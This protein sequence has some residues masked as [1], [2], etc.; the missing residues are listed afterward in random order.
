VS[1]GE[2]MFQ[3]RWLAREVMRPVDCV[4]REGD[5]AWSAAGRLFQS[6]RSGAPVLDSEGRLVGV[7]SQSDLAAH[8]RENSRAA[9]DFYEEPDRDPL[10]ARPTATVGQLMSRVIV[11]VPEDMPVDDVERHMLRRR[12]QRV[13]VTREGEVLGVITATDL[14]RSR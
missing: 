13:L 9:S 2:P 4:L 7:I 12:V 5:D 11:Q 14:L 6:G 10:P 1:P 8:L 3:R